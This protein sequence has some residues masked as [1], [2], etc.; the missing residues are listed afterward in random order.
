[1]LVYGP[2]VLRMSSAYWAAFCEPVWVSVGMMTLNLLESEPLS[3]KEAEPLRGGCGLPKKSYEGGVP[4][5]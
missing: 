1:M 2:L 4:K 3:E 5:M